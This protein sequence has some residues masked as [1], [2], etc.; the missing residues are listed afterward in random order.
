MPMTH[1][2][3]RGGPQCLVGLKT[4]PYQLRATA[5]GRL[6]LDPTLH[7]EPQQFR[8]VRDFGDASDH[9][10]DRATERHTRCSRKLLRSHTILGQPDSRAEKR[11][12]T[13]SARDNGISGWYC[14]KIEPPSLVPRKTPSGASVAPADEPDCASTAPVEK[15]FFAYLFVPP[16]VFASTVHDLIDC[17]HDL[18]PPEPWVVTIR[19]IGLLEY[20]FRSL[21]RRFLHQPARFLQYYLRPSASVL[22]RHQFP[23]PPSE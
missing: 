19:A 17:L 11:E 20:I 23:R 22:V 12:M 21:R 3:I 13:L 6:V 15:A 2:I 7:S 8:L 9:A 1:K 10:R 18:V 5:D 16:H 4:G 14:L